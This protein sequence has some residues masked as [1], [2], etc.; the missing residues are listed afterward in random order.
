MVVSDLEGNKDKGNAL[1]KDIT[2]LGRSA[3]W[4]PCD[5]RDAASVDAALAQVDR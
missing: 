1:V 3:T 2:A 5:V 4:A